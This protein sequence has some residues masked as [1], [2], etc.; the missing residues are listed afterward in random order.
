MPE[1]LEILPP[2]LA[3]NSLLKVLP[4]PHIDTEIIDVSLSLGKV[5]ALDVFSPEALPAFTRSTMDGYA[6]CSTDTFGTSETLPGYLT[7]VGEVPMGATPGFSIKTGEA[8]LIHTGG[9][10]PIGAD[11]VLMLE[12][13]QAS[14]PG[15]I[16]VLRAVAAGENLV[17]KGEDVAEGQIIIPR[18]T[19][20]RP[21]EI[22]GMMA[23]GITC[24]AVFRSP[25]IAVISS[26]DEVIPANSFPQPGQVR[27]INSHSLGA[28]IIQNGGEPVFYGVV[29]D[30]KEALESSLNIA[31]SECDMVVIT[32]G[33]SASQRDL[34]SS[35][36]DSMGRPGVLV[37]GINIRP[38]K[39]TILAI[40]QNKPI[41]GLPG[42][43]VSALVIAG[44]FVVPVIDR[45]LG[46]KKRPQQ[47]VP[48]RLTVNLS[49][50]AGREDWVP[51]TLEEK[52]GM[53]YANPVFYKSNLI[54]SLVRADGLAYIS[55]PL[56]GMAVGDLVQVFLL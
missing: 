29:P 41:I 45:L 24:L 43:P 50:A 39:P 37:H 26:G 16:E 21:A 56:N 7:L 35:V 17:L 10:L 44:L 9:M 25:K 23:L 52:Q 32:A 13:T 42:N 38:G 55:A 6:V 22:G 15:E 19:R 40:C 27:D 8:A 47:Q 4:E 46:M 1:F 5:T 28:L 48:A 53:M 14:R 51:V 2:S 54:F 11:A 33:S 31:L 12:Y 34:T 30:R 20:V 18:G 3:L 49:S 36:I